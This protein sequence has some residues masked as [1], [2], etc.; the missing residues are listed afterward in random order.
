VSRAPCVV[1]ATCAAGLVAIACLMQQAEHHELLSSP[2]VGVL[3][4]RQCCI[5][6]TGNRQLPYI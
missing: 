1:C 3:A 6:G 2:G 4:V 5:S